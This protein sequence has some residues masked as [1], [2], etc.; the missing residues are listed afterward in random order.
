MTDQYGIHLTRAGNKQVQ[1]GRFVGSGQV[2]G[3]KQTQQGRFTG[4]GQAVGSKALSIQSQEGLAMERAIKAS[5]EELAIERAIKASQ[6]T[7]AMERAIKASQEELEMK[8]SIK[9]SQ[10]ELAM[11]RDKS[12][13]PEYLI[14]LAQSARLGLKKEEK[15]QGVE[16][17]VMFRTK[18]LELA[19][20]YYSSQEIEF[21]YSN[22]DNETKLLLFRMHLLDTPSDKELP[23]IING[24]QIF[25]DMTSNT[26]AT[27]EFGK[28]L[29]M[30]KEIQNYRVAMRLA[31]QMS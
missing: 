7:M 3:T 25:Y 4:S 16:T 30:Y 24:F 11:E 9:A 1:P 8:R 27:R 17:P 20:L 15:S 6:E 14:R 28:R 19:E 2:V 31:L 13:V 5:Q 10:E 22:C 29:T 23:Y 12:V 18:S 26:D 21:D